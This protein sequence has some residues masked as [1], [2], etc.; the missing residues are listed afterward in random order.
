M[1]GHRNP[2]CS[3]Q[4]SFAAL[5]SGFADQLEEV[6]E[7]AEVE[8]EAKEQLLSGRRAPS[9]LQLPC[10]SV[11]GAAACNGCQARA[12]KYEWQR[13]LA[14]LRTARPLRRL[15][16]RGANRRL[17]AEPGHIAGDGP[18]KARPPTRRAAKKSRTMRGF[19]EQFV[20]V[21]VQMLQGSDQSQ[22]MTLLA[23]VLSGM[24][25]HNED[26]SSKGG[27]AGNG[28]GG[29]GGGSAPQQQPPAPR[30]QQPDA[31]EAWQTVWSLRPEDFDA[32]IFSVDDLELKARAQPGD[33]TTP[34]KPVLGV[35]LA[36]DEADCKGIETLLSIHGHLRVL[37]VRP[38]EG[39]VAS[40]C[41][42]QPHEEPRQLL[43]KAR[44]HTRVRAVGL[45]RSHTDAPRYKTVV[46]KA[47]PAAAATETAV[48]RVSVERRY[49][50]EWERTLKRPG[51]TARAW[52][53]A[54]GLTD[55]SKLRDTFK[56]FQQGDILVGLWRVEQSAVAG[57]LAAS[58][59][60]DDHGHR[61][62]VE[63]MRWEAPNP[64]PCAC[65]YQKRLEDEEWSQYATRIASMAGDLGIARGD[66]AL[67]IRKPRASTDARTR[68][69][70]LKA[71]AL[72]RKT[73][74]VRAAASGEL[75]GFEIEQRVAGE[76][77]HMHGYI[78][79]PRRSAAPWQRLPGERAVS[80][81]K[82]PK[83]AEDKPR[84]PNRVLEMAPAAGALALAN[85][86]A[87]G[88]AAEN[89]GNGDDK[90]SAQRPGLRKQN[91]I[92]E[93]ETVRFR[94][95]KHVAHNCDKFANYWDEL[96]PQRED[97]KLDS[98]AEYMKLAEKPGAWLGNLEV[99]AF[100]E[101]FQGEVV[102]YR[103]QGPPQHFKPPS[104]AKKPL[105][106]ASAPQGFTVRQPF[107][108]QKKAAH[109]AIFHAKVRDQM[110]LRPSLVMK[111]LAGTTARWQC[112]CCPKAMAADPASPAGARSR[113]KHGATEHPDEDPKRFHL[114]AGA[115]GD[116]AP[117]LAAAY[118]ARAAAWRVKNLLG[119]KTLGHQIVFFRMPAGRRKGL[120]HVRCTT[121]FRQGRT[122][123]AFGQCRPLS[124][125]TG[126]TTQAIATARGWL[127]A[128]P[129]AEHAEI[130]E[131][132]D[133][134][135][136]A[137]EQARSREL[138]RIRDERKPDRDKHTVHQ[139]QWPL[140]DKNIKGRQRFVCMACG[141]LKISRAALEGRAC[142][143]RMTKQHFAKRVRLLAR[144]RRLR[145]R[146]PD[147]ETAVEALAKARGSPTEAAEAA[148]EAAAAAA[149]RGQGVLQRRRRAQ[150]CS[151]LAARPATR[152]MKTLSWF[153]ASWGLLRQFS[154][155]RPAAARFPHQFSEPRPAAAAA[156]NMSRLPPATTTARNMSRFPPA[157]AA[158]AQFLQ[159]LQLPHRKAPRLA[160]HMAA[161]PGRQAQQQARFAG[162]P[163]PLGP[164]EARPDDAGV[165][166]TAGPE[167][168]AAAGAATKATKPPTQRMRIGTLNVQGLREKL[169]RVFFLA[170]L[171]A[172]DVLC[173]Q[174]ARIGP[175]SLASLTQ[176]A[177][178]RGYSYT[179]AAETDIDELGRAQ[180]GVITFSRHP[181]QR[182]AHPESAHQ[183]RYVTT[184][185]HMPKAEPLL[186]TNMHGLPGRI[187]ETWDI[188]H[189]VLA[190]AAQLGRRPVIIGDWN[191]IPSEGVAAE[192]AS[193][194]W[195][196]LAHT[197]AETAT[198][199]HTKGR[200]LD[201]MLAHPS[202]HVSKRVQ[203]LMVADHSL[204][205]H[206][207]PC[208]RPEDRYTYKPHQQLPEI[209]PPASGTRDGPM[210]PELAQRWRE[211]QE[212]I[213]D[214]F[215]AA[216]ARFDTEAMWTLL[217]D[218]TERILAG[219]LTPGT[220]SKLFR[221]TWGSSTRLQ[222][223]VQEEYEKRGA[224][225]PNAHLQRRQERLASRYPDLQDMRLDTAA[226][227]QALQELIN[228][229]EAHHNT[230]RLSQWTDA[231]VTDDARTLQWLKRTA[232]PPEACTSVRP[233]LHPQRE[234]EHQ[235]AAWARIWCSEPPPNTSADKY[236]HPVPRHSPGLPDCFEVDRTGKR[237][238][239]RAGRMRAKAAGAD[240]WKPKHVADLPLE[241]FA[242]LS[243]VWNA[244]LDGGPVP[245]SWTHTR[246]ALIPKH[247]DTG[248]LRPI[249]IASVA[250][251]LG[252]GDLVT[253]L[254]PWMAAWLHPGIASGARRDPAEMVEALLEGIDESKAAGGLSIY[255]AKIDLSKAFDRVSESRARHILRHMGAPEPLLHTLQSF[256]AQRQMHME[257]DGCVASQPIRP[258]RGLLQGCPL[259]VLLLLVDM[260]L[261]IR[262]VEASCPHVSVKAY[263]DDRTLWARGPLAK[264]RVAEACEVTRRFD[265]GAG[266]Q[267][268]AGKGQRFQRGH[269]D[270]RRGA[271]PSQLAALQG[272]VLEQV[273]PLKHAVEVLG[274]VLSM[275]RV[276]PVMT[277][278]K[279]E[280]AA[281]WQLSRIA[282]PPLCWG[283]R[284]MRPPQDTVRRWDNAIRRAILQHPRAAS[285][286][287][288]AAVVG[289]SACVEYQLDADALRHELWRLR[290]QARNLPTAVRM[291]PRWAAVCRR[292]RWTPR[293]QQGG[294]GGAAQ[295]PRLYDTPE[296]I[297]DLAEFGKSSLQ[298][299]AWRSHARHLWLQESRAKD[300]DS[301]RLLAAGEV[302]AGRL[303]LT[304]GSS[305]SAS[306]R[307][308]A[309]GCALE[310]H[311]VE[312]LRRSA[313]APNAA[314]V[315]TCGAPARRSHW[316]WECAARSQEPSAGPA[317]GSARCGLEEKMAVRIVEVPR[318]LAP[319]PLAALQGRLGRIVAALRAGQR[320][321]GSGALV[322]TDGSVVGRNDRLK[323]GAW[324]IAVSTPA[325]V[326]TATGEVSIPDGT[327]DCAEREAALH[328][329]R[330]AAEAGVAFIVYI[331]NS[332]VQ[333]GLRDILM[334]MPRRQEYAFGHWGAIEGH[335]RTLPAGCAAY[336]VPSHG[337]REGSWAPPD[338][339]HS[340]L[341][342]R[343][344]NRAADEAC[345]ERAAALYA[346]LSAPQEA[347]HATADASMAAGMLRLAAGEQALLADWAPARDEA[348]LQ[349]GDMWRRRTGARRRRPAAGQA[350]AA[351]AAVAPGAPVP[352]R[353][354]AALP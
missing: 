212:Q 316:L 117:R 85:G 165:G 52:G 99:A 187:V 33:S 8:E 12:W 271:S 318:R 124:A 110:H 19:M 108:Y 164:L 270:G 280:A 122:V 215:D 281:L 131:Y 283:G 206:D 74:V 163:D 183:G 146:S 217:S 209:P 309:L 304:F 192:A 203:E 293:P 321:D 103:R 144:L 60:V 266:W 6:A 118:A 303:R 7:E 93:Q 38:L 300:A 70:K 21:M 139:F 94:I 336:W 35:V 299:L 137:R 248:G 262:V 199:T 167:A 221:T 291:L 101:V 231:M 20:K 305:G 319:A 328:L 265:L 276:P 273:G 238:R 123:R 78:E 257:V 182:M 247:D 350:A 11:G 121:C 29:G 344:L 312:G 77:I 55:A 157:A 63:P 327:S 252:M 211:A 324:A 18:P 259:S 251:R 28:S 289:P 201:Y 326:V 84:A 58:G 329:M 161:A 24:Q 125:Q 295:Y 62:F 100:A 3:L 294:A 40:E 88:A 219:Q 353:A 178:R 25:A 10:T 218:E 135:L 151:Y 127:E 237:L 222:R 342:V 346:R 109:V 241:W 320:A 245:H 286:A 179:A 143:Q 14:Q 80:F 98:F 4:L 253:T 86:P 17:R 269:A 267:W 194:G 188:V 177:K 232:A 345:G 200:H 23:G 81:V 306:L 112:P 174:E 333:G 184:A 16:H 39:P 205:H 138:Q 243:R 282:P 204:V 9:Q 150:R 224:T 292:W 277:R 83:S 226:G 278:R 338:P 172:L 242:L 134:L 198:A 258:L 113:L 274:V 290:R 339:R 120:T 104:G 67:G 310:H 195:L 190:Q 307:R 213:Q 147:L 347:L 130:Q 92:V 343:D 116:G 114:P 141:M 102:V 44:G 166:A 175:Q 168:A 255:G 132:L 325:G 136:K 169:S 50:T 337:K 284:F 119:G 214:D 158:A 68:T 82:D 317:V 90:G 56:W 352:R 142:G 196:R 302:P 264:A 332:G 239:W 76:D 323:R 216:E 107:L 54:A 313:G 128:A 322:C 96:A 191:M 235:R 301:Q 53:I 129:P 285:R 106:A 315:C 153:L 133:W 15:S 140:G 349:A 45:R 72:P 186:L 31:L 170:S 66:R 5:R 250:W 162:D 51:D 263:A 348:S 260:N 171:F 75:S 65:E 296:G 145:R 249:G 73:W 26:D 2:T 208:Y 341:E 272:G 89:G 334:G 149:P 37:R 288:C 42:L 298:Q 207:L 46:T 126:K 275:Q 189:A 97:K 111:L 330:A 351:P 43:G 180:G 61:F 227:R 228:H 155:P 152:A 49:T 57:L 95:A 240:G 223:V 185:L 1:H 79:A 297:V 229:V 230:R 91:V 234:A 34:P 335:A 176:Y 225:A 261:W 197:P 13:C 159:L 22:L 233:N 236:S 220:R 331:D 27:G 47:A 254:W 311:A 160:W 69:W 41:A 30:R 314:V 340:E 202:V 59:Q 148:A 64:G 115:R 354:A 71:S 244:I 87:I 308:A 48:L 181:L 193:N 246:V 36:R 210:A 156:R 32:H 154:E 173:V 287:A 256:Y 105:Q 268:N 279:S